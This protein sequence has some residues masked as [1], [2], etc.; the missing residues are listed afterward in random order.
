MTG[1]KTGFGAVQE[2]ID[3]S[4]ERGQGGG[5]LRTLVW[6]DDRDGKGELY[7]HTLRFLTDDVVPCEIY[8]FIPCKD[9]KKRDFIIPP[10]GPDVVK[11]SGIRVP[12]FGNK[13]NLIEPKAKNVSLGIAVL[14]EEVSEMVDGRRVLSY[15]DKMETVSY[16][17]DGQQVEETRP[18]YVLVKQSNKNFWGIVG[19][20]WGRYGTI[21]DRDYDITR[22]RN[23]KDTNYTIIPCD[24]IDGLKTEEEVSKAYDPP[25]T[26]E[27]IIKDLSSPERA[28]KLL[29]GDSEG[30]Q[31]GG[32]SSEGEKRSES[33]EESKK[34]EFDSLRDQLIN[35]G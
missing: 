27:S 28:R 3:R 34:T 23:D 9:N 12:Q 6:K 19:G 1:F 17:K 30:G 11:E 5:F 32:G 35:Q 2:A 4:A 25:I 21:T 16:E 18:M 8:E 24:P 29:L 7:R 10:N 33:A 13:N 20:Y 22:N 14:R 26:L 31:D 15:K